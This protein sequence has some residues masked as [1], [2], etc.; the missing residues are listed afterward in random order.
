MLSSLRESSCDAYL[1]PHKSY[2]ALSYTLPLADRAPAN[3]K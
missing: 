2:S 3:P 1:A